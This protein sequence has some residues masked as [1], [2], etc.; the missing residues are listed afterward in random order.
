MWKLGIRQTRLLINQVSAYER[1][2]SN[3]DANEE[4]VLGKKRENEGRKTNL[5]MK[6]EVEAS[7]SDEMLFFKHT[8]HIYCFKYSYV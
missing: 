6:K 3:K 4:L 2:N 5:E 1:R 8:C 7:I